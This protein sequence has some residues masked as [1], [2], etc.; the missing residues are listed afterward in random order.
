MVTSSAREALLA[1]AVQEIQSS[2]LSFSVRRI[3]RR[4]N[5]NQGLIPYYFGDGPSLIAETV[6]LAAQRFEAQFEAIAASAPTALLAREALTASFQILQTQPD[7]FRLRR[8]L[9]ALAEEAPPGSRLRQRVMEL[10]ERALAL[11]SK[12][13]ARARG[14]VRATRADRAC[15]QLL[16]ATF[17]GLAA[18]QSAGMAIDVGAATAQLERWVAAK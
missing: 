9:M 15:A 7:H 1:A 4:A 13:V 17:D 5:L 3:A 8:A 6:D 10:T 16:M 11:T 14:R 2:A 18:Q 12:L